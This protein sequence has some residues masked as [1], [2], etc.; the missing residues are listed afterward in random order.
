MFKD[1]LL[2]TE[3][4][5]AAE[6]PLGAA[7]N[8]VPMPEPYKTYK[9]GLVGAQFNC[10]RA[11]QRWMTVSNKHSNEARKMLS[12][13]VA[14]RDQM[15]TREGLFDKSLISPQQLDQYSGR[16]E[17]VLAELTKLDLK[18]GVDAAFAKQ[19]Y[20]LA[21]R[22][23]EQANE[24]LELQLEIKQNWEEI[25][26]LI[27]HESE[28]LNSIYHNVEVSRAYV[29]KAIEELEVVEERTNPWKLCKRR[30]IWFCIFLT[31]GTLI[32]LAIKILT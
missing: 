5:E 28:Q 24:V 9:S 27:D 18:E 17:Q 7:E 30:C 8:R 29:D 11:Q 13:H 16:E 20:F 12:K 4:L 23:E 2:L 1:Q 32:F 19:H 10:Q 15:H 14:L 21:R 26:M 31:L 6:D 25:S 3:K 22:K